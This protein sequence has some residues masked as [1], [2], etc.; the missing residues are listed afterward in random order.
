MTRETWDELL[1]SLSGAYGLKAWRAEL[2]YGSFVTIEFGERQPGT[3]YGSYHLWIY[4]ASWRLEDA[5]RML[6]ASEDHRDELAEKVPILD[7]R[8][9]TSIAVEY[10]SLST[11]FEFEGG[12]SL[13]TFSV[14]S[15]DTEHWKLFRPDGMV[16]TAEAGSSFWIERADGP[17]GSGYAVRR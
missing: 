6:A 3:D 2:G 5:N 10:P 8:A 15:T 7:G 13:V 17:G 12:L 11:R 9:L 4:M 1:A 14:Y 16:V